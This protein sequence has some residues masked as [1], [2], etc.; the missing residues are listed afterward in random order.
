[1]G[2]TIAV[3]GTISGTIVILGMFISITFVADHGTMGMVAG[4]LSMLAALLFVFIGVKRYR[5]VNLG[6]VITFWKA[7]GV[8][9]GIGLVAA[10]FYVLSWEVYM[11]QSGGTFMTEY[12]AKTIED[13]RAAGKS[14][15]EIEKFS[16]EMGA[17]AE[18]YKNPLFRM[19]LT[20]TEILP[21]ALLVALV[22]AALLRKSS[23]LPA[24][25]PRG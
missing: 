7:L 20:L 15:A 12:I 19:A 16:S 11:W 22:S 13:M 8:G 1:M 5:D 21:V 18:Q 6:G 9:L 24:T 14:G 25:Q 3:Y 4:Y 23:F 2:R 10:L 17:M